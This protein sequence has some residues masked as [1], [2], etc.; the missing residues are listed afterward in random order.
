MSK[1]IS[2]KELRKY[3]NQVI[4]ESVFNEDIYGHKIDN[5]INMYRDKKK[6]FDRLG[7]GQEFLDTMQRIV[8]PQIHNIID[9]NDMED[10]QQYYPGFTIED[11]P[12]LLQRFKSE[13][14]ID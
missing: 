2:L 10:I 7:M 11:F 1:N 14:W 3:V 8:V 6:N 9:G 4:K 12:Y 13:G 5:V